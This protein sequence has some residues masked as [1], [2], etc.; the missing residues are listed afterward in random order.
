MFNN[1]LLDGN[2]VENKENSLLCGEEYNMI[3]VTAY[4]IEDITNIV[5]YYAKANFFC[6][7]EH[8]NS[9]FLLSVVRLRSCIRDNSNW[10]NP[11]NSF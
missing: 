7:S 4:R 10:D 5:L 2:R 11:A 8:K 3:P 1:V 9:L 6:V